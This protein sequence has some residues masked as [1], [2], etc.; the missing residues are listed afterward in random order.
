[1]KLW[2]LSNSQESWQNAC[3][4]SQVQERELDSE[5]GA[6]QPFAQHGP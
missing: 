2:D 4:E 3:W 1:M 6:F 5:C